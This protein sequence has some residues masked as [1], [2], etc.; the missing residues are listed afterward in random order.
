MR[1]L[2]AAVVGSAGP[3]GCP[4]TAPPSTDSP[5][6]PSVSGGLTP[7]AEGLW[8]GIATP[9]GLTLPLAP[10]RIENARRM[11]DSCTS[12]KRRSLRV[13]ILTRRC[14]VHPEPSGP[15]SCLN[16]EPR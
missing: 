9:P 15:E 8:P 12:R 11:R 1:G 4:V 13:R 3:E 10:V 5:A 16:P 2:P 6:S 14:G 7:F